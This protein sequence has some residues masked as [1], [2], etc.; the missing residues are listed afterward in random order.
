MVGA[1]SRRAAE[2]PL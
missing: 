1:E 2:K